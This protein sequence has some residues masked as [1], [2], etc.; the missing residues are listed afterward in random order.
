MSFKSLF[1][2]SE[3]NAN[4]KPKQETTAVD[5]SHMKFPTTETKSSIFNVFSNSTQP[6]PTNVQVSNEHLSKMLESY[7]NGFDSLN[8]A[9]YD[10]YEFYQAVSHGGLDNPQIYSMAFAMGLGMDKTI[11]KDKLV[12]QAEFYLNEIAK[13]YNDNVS[14]GN[15]KKQEL[16]NQKN[17]ENQSLV[18]ELDLMQQQMEALKTQIQDRQNKLNAIGSKYEPMI[19]DLDGK[20]AANDVAKNQLV[21]TIQQVKNGIINNLK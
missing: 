15:N 19:N 12:N 4:E 2:N 9:G 20:L 16:V 10:F 11:T 7:N 1:L 13:V 3:E 21:G 18:N 5:T 8:Q 6:T 14:K 17:N